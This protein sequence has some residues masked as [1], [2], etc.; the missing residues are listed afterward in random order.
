MTTFTVTRRRIALVAAFL[1]LLGAG[2]VLT[3]GLAVLH[4][5]RLD[6]FAWSWR[7]VAG[8]MALAALLTSVPLHG[9]EIAAGGALWP[10]ARGAAILLFVAFLPSVLAQLFFM[11]GVELIGAARA[12]VFANL[13]P[14][15]GPILAVL[16]LGE[17]FG[18]H[19]LV[20]LALVLGGIVVA[21]RAGRPPALPQSAA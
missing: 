1:L 15:F 11:R 9:L 19:H 20:G 8:A 2:A 18:L 13:V 21:E 12:G 17:P 7:T 5:G 6:R 14:V 16:V 4:D 3:A 10:T